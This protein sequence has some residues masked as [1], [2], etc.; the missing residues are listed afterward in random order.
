MRTK[1]PLASLFMLL[2]LLLI[3]YLVLA[4]SGAPPDSLADHTPLKQASMQSAPIETRTGDVAVRFMT[5][6]SAQITPTL[7]Y[8]S[9][10]PIVIKP[11][12]P[13]C[14]PPTAD[15][16]LQMSDFPP[17]VGWQPDQDSS[18]TPEETKEHAGWQQ[19]CFRGYVN[20]L[21]LLF[22]GTGLVVNEVTL[23]D[24]SEH[25]H[26]YYEFA[27]S[28]LNPEANPTLIEGVDIGDETAAYHLTIPDSDGESHAI[29]FRRG[30]VMVLVT[31]GNAF[32]PVVLQD[33]VY[34]AE[35]VRD[36]IDGKE[37]VTT[38][39][40]TPVGISIDPEIQQLLD[41][42]SKALQ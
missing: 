25:A 26:A 7:A 1:R 22:G 41:V 13:S 40:V 9:Y 3:S 6:P 15:W 17:A 36:R 27:Q 37:T 33:A 28:R 29:Y 4:L 11:E 19:S 16:S 35:L 39:D 31:T 23:F 18:E 12:P 21:L 42:L 32:G 30:S 34:W 14:Q 20:I 24:T 10:L 8:T 5:L 2:F 38:T